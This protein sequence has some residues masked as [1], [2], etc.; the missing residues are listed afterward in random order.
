MS[1]T[2]EAAEAQVEQLVDEE[3]WEEALALCRRA[4]DE[5]HTAAEES[6]RGRRAA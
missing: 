2:K 6:T 1:F 4:A 5:L 3:K